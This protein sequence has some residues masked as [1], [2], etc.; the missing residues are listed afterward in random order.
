M[1]VSHFKGMLKSWTVWFSAVLAAAPVW[2]PMLQENFA[3]I[4]PFIPEKRQAAFVQV[5]ALGVFL[6]RMKTNSSIASRGVKDA[7]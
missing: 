3:I 7:P 5:I 6:L 1:T 2:L 4:A